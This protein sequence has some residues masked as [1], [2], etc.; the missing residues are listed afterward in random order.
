M[1]KRIFEGIIGYLIAMF[2]N[3]V[4]ALFCSGRIGWF[5][6]LVLIMAP[7][8]SLVY[9][10]ISSKYIEINAVC[11]DRL[12][13]EEGHL[14]CGIEVKNKMFLPSPIVEI[15]FLDSEHISCE[16]KKEILSVLPRRSLSIYADYTAKIAGGSYIGIKSVHVKGFFSVVS[17]DI[18]EDKLE[19]YRWL[20]GVIPEIRDYNQGNQLLEETMVEAFKDGDSDES[21]EQTSYDFSGFP[22]YE[23]R[24][25]MPGDPLK[26]INSKA[27]A[28]QDKLLVRL[29]EKYAV[30][31]V[32]LVLDPIIND[33]ELYSANRCAELAKENLETIL[34]MAKTLLGKDFAVNLYWYKNHGWTKEVLM[35]EGDLVA[36]AEK[37]GFYIFWNRDDF[38]GIRYPKESK[39][40]GH[41]VVVTNGEGRRL[42]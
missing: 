24:E 41:A 14:R 40:L 15:E 12:L 13:C 36:L 28:K 25:Y 20:V 35:A 32:S 30:A 39:Q 1:K 9:A 31:A 23:Y 4:F 6:F 34:E 10:K 38:D 33:Y 27:S 42:C 7:L 5:L 18:S 17:F 2:W 22:G 3:I 37:F 21:I 26:R 29:D 11:E 16:C 19:E 8:L